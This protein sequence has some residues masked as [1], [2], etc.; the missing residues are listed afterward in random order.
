MGRA[1]VSVVYQLVVTSGLA[2]S[3]LK[4]GLEFFGG[5]AVE[6]SE[7]SEVTE[8]ADLLA[9]LGADGP[10]TPF[11]ADQ[12]LDILQV[13][14][15]PFIQ[16]RLA[17]GPLHEQAFMGGIVEPPPFT[18]TGVARGGGVE[19]PLM[20]V[21][22]T[23]LTAGSMLWRFFPG[24]TEPELR[25]VYHGIAWG[26]E[27]V[28]TGAFK[29]AVPSV[30]MGPVMEREWGM[31]PVEVELDEETHQPA[32]VTLVAP[33]EPRGE[34]GFEQLGSGLWG[35]RIEYRPDLNIFENQGIARFNNIPVRIVG[36]AQGEDGKFAAHVTSMV[37]DAPLTQALGFNRFSAATATVLA[38][39]EDL[40]GYA[41]REGRPKNW[42]I[43][44]RPA[45]TARPNKPRDNEDPRQLT[46]DIFGML[47]AI[48]PQGW[49]QLNLYVQLVG[50]VAKFA[51]AAMLPE[52]KKGDDDGDTTRESAFG[53][54]NAEPAL[55]PVTIDL[56]P[57]SILHYV[58]HLKKLLYK[59]E[60]GAPFVLRFTFSSDGQ[61]NLTINT[62][63][64]PRW[65]EQVP[66]NVWQA[67]LESF[68][69][70]QENIAQWLQARLEGT[71]A[72]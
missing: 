42:D 46:S 60:V 67:D 33:A 31:C 68:P 27:T 4:N 71:E 15:N 39:V 18:G 16:T 41:T 7:V 63:D 19:T 10:S 35:K 28:K 48:A 40:T 37:L 29:A 57:T 9:L 3:Y 47:A 49:K 50:Q 38:P 51:A 8:V 72:E 36:M 43:S 26:W 55:T 69:R 54:V 24:S 13:P 45:I 66:A 12:P 59:P 65:A 64:E 32:A 21:E 58:A 30:Y 5:F 14:A 53:N 25:G 62:T 11:A 52:E 23:R 56:L 22:P 20:W 2:E 1:V 17:V 44:E 61:A 6:A 70:T 34:E